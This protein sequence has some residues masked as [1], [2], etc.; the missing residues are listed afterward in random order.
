MGSRPLGE[1]SLHAALVRTSLYVFRNAPVL[2][3]GI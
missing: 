1:R 2:F 3:R